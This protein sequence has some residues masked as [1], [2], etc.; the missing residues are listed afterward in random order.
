MYYIHIYSNNILIVNLCLS[1]QNFAG[2][3]IHNW[4][5]E[6][7]VESQLFL[8]ILDKNYCMKFC[9]RSVD[10]KRRSTSL[11]KTTFASP[12]Q[13]TLVFDF[14]SSWRRNDRKQKIYNTTRKKAN[15]HAC[16]AFTAFVPIAYVQDDLTVVVVL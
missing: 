2:N 16:M 6:I 9:Q 1:S 4:D 15:T 3:N 5:I 7:Y 14:T 13:R 8:I 11:R 10:W 12:A